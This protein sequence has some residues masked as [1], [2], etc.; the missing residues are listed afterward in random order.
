MFTGG[1]CDELVRVGWLGLLVSCA[2]KSVF[3]RS[4]CQSLNIRNL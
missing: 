4:P 3:L 2:C 1:R